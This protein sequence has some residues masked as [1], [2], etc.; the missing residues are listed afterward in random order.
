MRIKLQNI[1]KRFKFEWI[2]KKIDYTF[3][4]PKQYAILG[5]NGSGKSTIL[6]ILAGHL[7]PSKGTIKFDLNGKDVGGDSFYKQVS[8]AAPYIDL[9]EEYTLIE[10]IKFHQQ[11]QS[12]KEGIG[13]QEIL[14]I[15]QLKK[16][17]NKEIRN[18][19][20]GMKQRL[21]LALAICSDTPMLLLDEPTSNLDEQGVAWYRDLIARYAQQRLVI[22]ASNVKVDYDFCDEILNITDYK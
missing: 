16:S 13:V 17:N 14:D 8:F 15:L 22:I 6:K 4:A 7:T 2:F 3:E 21:K 19:S 10:A 1:S 11:F 18:F 20:S 12:F 9:I 5:H